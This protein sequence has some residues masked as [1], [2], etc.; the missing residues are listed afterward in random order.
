MTKKLRTVRQVM[1][2]SIHHDIPPD[3]DQAQPQEEW[4]LDSHLDTLPPV[5]NWYSCRMQFAAYYLII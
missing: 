4:T 3:A 2:L 1:E 5:K